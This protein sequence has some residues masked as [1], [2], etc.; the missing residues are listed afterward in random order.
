MRLAVMAALNM[1]V[2]LLSLILTATWWSQWSEQ[3][4]KQAGLERGRCQREETSVPGG[5]CGMPLVAC[6]ELYEG[7]AY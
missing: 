7:D 2:L 1:P 3:R 4:R 5:S 6:V